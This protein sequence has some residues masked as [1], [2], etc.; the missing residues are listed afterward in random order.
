[1]D[2]NRDRYQQERKDF[3]RYI[4]KLIDS[5]ASFHP[6]M[7]GLKANKCVFRINKD[8]RFSKDKKP[9]KPWFSAVLAPGGKNSMYAGSYLHIQPGNHSMIGGGLRHPESETLRSI[10]DYTSVHYRKLDKIVF[11]KSF[12]QTYGEIQGDSV[13]TAPKG[14]SKEHPAI[15]Y[16]RMKDLYVAYPLSD[17]EIMSSK[18][19]DHCL[20]LIKIAQPFHAYLNTAIDEGR[21]ISDAEIFE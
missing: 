17:Q 12:R 1:M 20:E 19:L 11:T 9:Y 3:L 2:A 21:D 14:F 10:R 18:F 7:K 6:L 13:K 5:Y 4:Q 15:N 16:L 8:I